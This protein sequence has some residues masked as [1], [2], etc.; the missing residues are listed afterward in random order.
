MRYRSVML[1]ASR[2]RTTT[3]MSAQFLTYILV[4]FS[5]SEF[6]RGKAHSSLATHSKVRFQVEENLKV[7]FSTATEARSTPQPP[8][9]S[10][11]T[12]RGW[13]NL[14]PN[15]GNLMTIRRWRSSLHSLKRRAVL[16]KV[17][18]RAGI[19]GKRRFLYPILSIMK[20]AHTGTTIIAHRCRRKKVFN[21][22]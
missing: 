4:G 16:P 17:S 1:R 21:W 11:F 22:T 12:K 8:F 3:S 10:S 14:T 19:P 15:L 6:C 9:A 2:L 7:C 5:L 13:C 18:F 20:S